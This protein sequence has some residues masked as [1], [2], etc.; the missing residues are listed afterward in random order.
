MTLQTELRDARGSLGLALLLTVALPAPAGAQA[1]GEIVVEAPHRP[2]P[3]F[4]QV[5]REWR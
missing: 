1:T 4:E 3:T 5:A 2:R